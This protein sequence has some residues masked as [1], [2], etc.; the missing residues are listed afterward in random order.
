MRYNNVRP[1]VLTAITINK[2]IYWVLP[3]CSSV[4]IHV[5][6]KAINR[7]LLHGRRASVCL[8]LT[9]CLACLSSTPNIKSM[10]YPKPS[11]KF[12]R[13]TQSYNLCW[14]CSDVEWMFKI[15]P[16]VW[17]TCVTVVLSTKC[18][19]LNHLCYKLNV[20]CF[21][22][23]RLYPT[24]LVSLDQNRCHLEMLSLRA[25][26]ISFVSCFFLFPSLELRQYKVAYH[27]CGQ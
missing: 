8:L 22:I 26:P 12:Y 9:S 3:L 18:F 11:V 1:E 4:E 24:Y 13:I 17:F 19:C 20:C 5:C 25:N 16:S 21:H 23:R 15:G 10:H 27:T 6:F 2:N 7:L 14:H